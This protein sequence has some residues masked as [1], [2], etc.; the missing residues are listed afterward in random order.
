MI[1]AMAGSNALMM[2]AVLGLAP[3]GEAVLSTK[4]ATSSP[5]RGKERLQAWA[6]CGK[7]GAS[8]VIAYTN[9]MDGAVNVSVDLQGLA[10]QQRR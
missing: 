9:A 1:P 2:F 10:D 5:N 6:F 8:V 7:S 3:F 4:I